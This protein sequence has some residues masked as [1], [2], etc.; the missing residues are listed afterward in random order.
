MDPLE[1]AVGQARQRHVLIIG[2]AAGVAF[3]V[4]RG[5]AW[6][7]PDG[8]TAP[9]ALCALALSVFAPAYVT[10]S[11]ELDRNPLEVT[12]PNKPSEAL[13]M[14]VAAC[15]AL[16]WGQALLQHAMQGDPPLW[17]KLM[18]R[19]LVPWNI[20]ILIAVVAFTSRAAALL[21][22]FGLAAGGVACLSVMVDGSLHKQLEGVAVGLGIFWVAAVGIAMCLF[23]TAKP[24]AVD[25]GLER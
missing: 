13:R 5:L 22:V 8:A 3:A 1:A 19:Q 23:K 11:A 14:A 17:L 4:L 9:W 24:P 15:I 21:R 2:G 12:E 6:M 18:Q 7:M 10:F 20:A 25:D 16:A